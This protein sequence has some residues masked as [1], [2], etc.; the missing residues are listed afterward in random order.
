MKTSQIIQKYSVAFFILSLLP[1]QIFCASQDRQKSKR[2][3]IER[4]V[5]FDSLSSL[6]NKRD[7]QSEQ[8]IPLLKKYLAREGSASI[9]HAEDENGTL[10]YQACD[11]SI[12]SID[13]HAEIVEALLDA[14][15]DVE[16][17]SKDSLDMT[18]L[19]VSREP[20]IV[21]LLLRHGASIDHVDPIGTSALLNAL[22]S[23][24]KEVAFT[25][26]KAGADL[27]LRTKNGF[28][29]LGFALGGE[30]PERC[31]SEGCFHEILI[32]LLSRNVDLDVPL[33][34]QNET[35]KK[36]AFERRCPACL[37]LIYNELKKRPAKIATAVTQFNTMSHMVRDE[38]DLDELGLGQY[39]AAYAQNEKDSRY[40]P[41]HNLNKN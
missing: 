13:D 27:N 38:S 5:T 30:H 23:E 31:L 18:P 8:F 37:Y 26:M 25:L 19:M 10:L 7:L 35:P 39:I 1:A 16:F 29:P 17:V 4:P 3:K 36:Y 20:E 15:A 12:E 40:A 34:K 6:L 32:N 14:K 22:F 28:T 21:K 24:E 41:R 33:N 9:N 11:S 2:R